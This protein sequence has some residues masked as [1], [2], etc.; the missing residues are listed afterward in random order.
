MQHWWREIWYDASNEG[1]VERRE[2]SDVDDSK[3]FEREPEPEGIAPELP[4]YGCFPRIAENGDDWIHPDDRELVSRLIPSERM[5]CRFAFDGTYYTYSYGP[6]EFRLKPTLWLEVDSEGIEIGD[7][8]ETVGQGME[9]EL[10]IAVVWGIYYVRRKGRL[11]Y[12]L[13]RSGQPVP[14]LFRSETLRLLTNKSKVRPGEI[15]HPTPT[16]DG[17][18]KRIDLEE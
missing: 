4:K 11:L 10:F 1:S 15:E 5:M 9:R 17:S 2:F 7:S 6:H 12:R 14:G 18:G 13:K 16:W 3:P 8:V